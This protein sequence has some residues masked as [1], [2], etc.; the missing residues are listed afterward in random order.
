MKYPTDTWTADC[1]N[2]VLHT[3]ALWENQSLPILRLFVTNTI[4][5]DQSNGGLWYKCYS[6]VYKPHENITKLTSVKPII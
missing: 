2:A 4:T 6:L 3:A 5:N 1:Y